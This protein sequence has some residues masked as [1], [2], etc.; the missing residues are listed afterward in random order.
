MKRSSALIGSVWFLFLAPGMVAGLA[1]WW[2]AHGRAIS[3]DWSVRLLA[4]LL[5]MPGALLVLHAF[6]RFVVDGRGT[7]APFA[8]TTALVTNGPYRHVRNPMYVAVLAIIAGQGL[9]YQSHSIWLYGLGVALLFLA[10]VR[11]HEEP[12]LQRQY[13]EAYSR[14]LRNVPGWL[15]RLRP[16]RGGAQ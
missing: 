4:V 12:A 8:P 13:G 5:I 15:P 14:Y 10:F 11:L 7:P 16:W 9:L 6:W 2:L 3:A 1:P